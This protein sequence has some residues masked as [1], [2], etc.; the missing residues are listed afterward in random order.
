[1]G[2]GAEV[3]QCQGFARVL[4][5]PTPVPTK[6]NEVLGWP[7]LQLRQSRST[8][9]G[10]RFVLDLS[11]SFFCSS[12][13]NSEHRAADKAYQV[14]LSKHTIGGFSPKRKNVSRC[15]VKGLEPSVSTTCTEA[16]ADG[17]GRCAVGCCIRYD[18]RFLGLRGN[19]PDWKA[20]L[21]RLDHET[22]SPTMI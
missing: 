9:L 8:R 6:L 3:Y 2:R 16:M 15:S 1:V 12:F 5:N 19:C 11:V 13:I 17:R 10:A 4:N 7:L 18:Q 14:R 22:Q 21:D 20:P